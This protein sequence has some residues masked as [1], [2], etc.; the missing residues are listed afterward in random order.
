[1]RE[2]YG[3]FGPTLCADM[4]G[5]PFSFR[6]LV[7]WA[8]RNNVKWVRAGKARLHD[9]SA[10]MKKNWLEGKIV[11]A[12]PEVA[13]KRGKAYAERL[14]SGEQQHARGMLGKKH[15]AEFCAEQSRRE[16][17]RVQDGTHHFQKKKTQKQLTAASRRLI[18]R[19]KFAPN[20][21]YSHAKRGYRDDLGRIFF[22]SRWE[23]NYARYLNLLIAQGHILRWEFEVDT[24]WFEK[25]RRGVRSYTPDFKVYGIDGSVW[26][27]E[28]KGWMDKKSATKLKRMAKYHPSVT[29]RVVDEKA[30]KEIA[31]KL[32]SVIPLWEK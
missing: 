11:K 20:S 8:Y 5:P 14:A 3:D 28:V 7:M 21:I 1:L 2:H 4:L 27:E 13:K 30:Y 12:S 32:S 22:R 31:K 17:Q 25:I 6:G 19:V 10:V 23:A 16:R 18:E 9:Q 24:F 29:V 15:S 26:Y